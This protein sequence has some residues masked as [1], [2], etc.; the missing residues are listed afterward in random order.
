MELVASKTDSAAALPI[1]GERPE[2]ADAARNRERILRAARDLIAQKGVREITLEQVAKAAGVGRATL[3]RRFPDRAALLLALLDEHERGLQDAILEGDPPLGPGAGRGRRLMA[4]AEAL[5]DLTHEHVE[6][7]LGSET[8]A[9]L[10]RMRT[11]AYAVWHLHLA[12]L[13][14]ELR[15]EADPDVLAD[16]ILGLYDA[17][18]QQFLAEERDATAVREL[19]LDSVRRLAGVRR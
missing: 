9:P 10:A 7:L 14:R 8:T 18:L 5:F 6:L 3:F 12:G 15:P 2:R 16:L 4:F 1:A 19:L 17:E 11:G 13:L